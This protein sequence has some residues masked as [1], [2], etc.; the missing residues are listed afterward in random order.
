MSQDGLCAAAQQ[1]SA[2]VRWPHLRRILGQQPTLEPRRQWDPMMKFAYPR[3]GSQRGRRSN[4]SGSASEPTPL[5]TPIDAMRL[6]LPLLPYAGTLEAHDDVTP[7]SEGVVL[8]PCH[9]VLATHSTRLT[10]CA[11]RR[12]RIPRR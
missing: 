7:P 5:H 12:N 1:V 6:Q 10:P 3:T 11:L 8:V 4:Q 9:A 2:H